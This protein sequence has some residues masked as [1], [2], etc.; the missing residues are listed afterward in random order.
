[1][2]VA[3]SHLTTSDLSL[4]GS[5][6]IAI[7]CELRYRAALLAYVVELEHDYV[8]LATVDAA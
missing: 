3:T 7:P 6:R 5:K 1:M 8:G 2:A 4:E